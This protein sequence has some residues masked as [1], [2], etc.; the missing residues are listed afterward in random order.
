MMISPEEYRKE[1]KNLTLEELSERKEKLEK[2]INDYESNNL[3][4]QEYLVKPSPKTKYELYKEYLD[5]VMIELGLR[6]HQSEWEGVKVFE[7]QCANC[8][9]YLGDINCKIYGEIDFDILGNKKVCPNRKDNVE[10]NNENYNAKDNKAINDIINEK[11]QEFDDNTANNL[12][13]YILEIMEKIIALPNDFETSISKIINY[14]PKSNFVDPLTQGIIF[15]KVSEICKE[16]KINLQLTYDDFGGL[17]FYYTFIKMEENKMIESEKNFEFLNK[18]IEK[19]T[20]KLAQAYD[21]NDQEQITKL[22]NEIKEATNRQ[23]QKNVN[24]LVK[25]D[26]KEKNYYINREVLLNK[27]GYLYEHRDKRK[28]YLTEK[29]FILDELKIIK[30]ELMSNEG[31]ETIYIPCGRAQHCINEFIYYLE[32]KQV[33]DCLMDIYEVI[34]SDKNGIYNPIINKDFNYSIYIGNEEKSIILNMVNRLEAYLNDSSNKYSTENL[35]KKAKEEFNYF[36]E[37]EYGVNKYLSLP[38]PLSYNKLK[39]LILLSSVHETDHETEEIYKCGYVLI[40]TITGNVEYKLETEQ[41]L[42]NNFKLNLLNFTPKIEI[43]INNKDD[44]N[45]LYDRYFKLLDDLILMYESKKEN[46][47]NSDK[48]KEFLNIYRSI[49]S[50][51]EQIEYS[52]NNEFLSWCLV[53]LQKQTIEKLDFEKQNVIMKETYID[54]NGHEQERERNIQITKFPSEKDKTDLISKIDAK[55]KD[56]NPSYEPSIQDNITKDNRNHN[57]KELID[58]TD[59]KIRKINDDIAKD[60]SHKISNLPDGTEFNFQ[61]F[62]NDYNITEEDKKLISD[63]ICDYCQNNNIVIVEKFHNTNIDPVWNIPRIKKST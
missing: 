31:F 12:K 34:E 17:A 2:F 21:N 54:E 52:L 26:L 29:D 35:F 37:N 58:K 30:N 39:S 9:N 3:S 61:Q 24:K 6:R 23:L 20:K 44:Y 63:L 8:K 48:I 13:K 18:S 47:E 11:L 15:N 43:P 1:L 41:L 49:A 46:I 60:I 50:E 53:S 19:L 42:S 4:E 40:D 59:E 36:V 62:M 38:L 33:N 27:L 14:N 16:I 56:V 7:S 25:E 45:N 51:S 28:N 10:G 57:V 22:Q 32:K 5:E 55:L